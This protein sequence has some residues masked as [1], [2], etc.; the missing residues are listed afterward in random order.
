MNRAGKTATVVQ[1]LIGCVLRQIQT[2]R[3]YLWQNDFNSN[4][5]NER[6]NNIKKEIIMKLHLEEN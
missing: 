2:K 3:Y 6:T 5:L 4:R 1:F